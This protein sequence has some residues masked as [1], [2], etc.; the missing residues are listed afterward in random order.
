MSTA[1]VGLLDTVLLRGEKSSYV[2]TALNDDGTIEVTT[3][4]LRVEFVKQTVNSAD[5]TLKEK[6]TTAIRSLSAIR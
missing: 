5:V 4:V 2:V 1:T 6:F 3:E